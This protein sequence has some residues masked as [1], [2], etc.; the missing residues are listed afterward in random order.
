[1]RGADRAIEVIEHREQLLHELAARFV[2]FAP[3]V[4]LEASFGRL[5]VAQGSQR[6][7]AVDLSLLTLLT[8][9]LLTLS[10]KP[11]YEDLPLFSMEAKLP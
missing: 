9:R 5:Q 3:G 6:R 1:V 11:L 8:L 10:W 7:L 2:G 4:A